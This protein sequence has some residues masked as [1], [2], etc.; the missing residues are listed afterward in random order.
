MSTTAIQ[1]SD[2][3][4]LHNLFCG[5]SETFTVYDPNER[6]RSN[7]II[8]YTEGDPCEFN[9]SANGFTEIQPMNFYFG[10]KKWSAG[11]KFIYINNPDGTMRWLVPSANNTASHLPLYNAES[12]KARV[13]KKSRVQAVHCGLT[14]GRAA[15]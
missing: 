15:T 11:K 14:T 10:R 9:L 1:Y 5:A 2:L 7:K 13:Y 6:L 3:Q 4:L 12:L 8:K